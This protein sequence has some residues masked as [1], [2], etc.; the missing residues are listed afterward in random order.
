M[1]VGDLTL[2]TRG[3]VGVEYL[4]AQPGGYGFN[5]RIVFEGTLH[6]IAARCDTSVKLGES[7]RHVDDPKYRQIWAAPPA[8]RDALS[9]EAAAIREQAAA[10]RDAVELPDGWVGIAFTPRQV[11]AFCSLRCARLDIARREKSQE[12]K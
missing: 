1:K 3:A 8:Q 10:A 6:C 5:G 7:T 2:N 12:D 9:A 11:G 4:D